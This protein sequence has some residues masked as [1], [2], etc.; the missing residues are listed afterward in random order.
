MS[1]PIQT[2]SFDGVFTI[3]FINKS[4]TSPTTFVWVA[5]N[6]AAYQQALDKFA[7]MLHCE[8]IHQGDS[9]VVREV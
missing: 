4:F 2:N 1:K 7:G 5:E 6:Q 8:I 9:H 3:A